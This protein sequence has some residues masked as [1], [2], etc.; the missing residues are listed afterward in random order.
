MKVALRSKLQ[1]LGWGTLGT[2]DQLRARYRLAELL[3][4]AR[5][6]GVGRNPQVSDV[7]VIKEQ[8]FEHYYLRLAALDLPMYGNLTTLKRRLHHAYEKLRAARDAE[9]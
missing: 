8:V 2:L 6:I 9:Q 5:E 1:A 7:N 4:T 3:E